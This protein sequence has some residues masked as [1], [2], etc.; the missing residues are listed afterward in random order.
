V[1]R[2]Q[3]FDRHVVIVRWNPRLFNARA[4]HARAL[5]R[6]LPG[7]PVARGRGVTLLTSDN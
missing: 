3:V 5:P 7:L 2:A 4:F 1:H 6:Y